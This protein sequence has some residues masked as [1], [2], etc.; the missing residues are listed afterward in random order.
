MWAQPGLLQ[1]LL[2]GKDQSS[3]PWRLVLAVRVQ[4]CDV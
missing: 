2:R 3:E 4:R 1:T